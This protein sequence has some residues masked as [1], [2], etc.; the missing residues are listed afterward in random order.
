MVMRH[1]FGVALR[2]PLSPKRII[3]SKQ[4]SLIVLTNRRVRVQIGT[5]RWKLHRGDARFP[6]QAQELGRKQRIAIM[7]EVPLALE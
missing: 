5:A 7:D 6:Q 2:T 3:R 1:E 4:D